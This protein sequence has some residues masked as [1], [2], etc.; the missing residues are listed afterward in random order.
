MLKRAIMW[1]F[2]NL[3]IALVILLRTIKKVE[4][5]KYLL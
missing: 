3:K 5:K 4:E 2:K 1:I